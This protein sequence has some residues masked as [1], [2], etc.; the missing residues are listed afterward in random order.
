[1]TVGDFLQWLA[2]IV[3]ALC[4]LLQARALRRLRREVKND[5]QI[6]YAINNQMMPHVARILQKLTETLP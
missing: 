4:A 5:R 3:L 2:I 1:V 6:L